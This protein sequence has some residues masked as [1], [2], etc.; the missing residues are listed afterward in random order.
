M[1][2]LF[3]T[4]IRHLACTIIAI[5]LLIANAD[6]SAAIF[7]VTQNGDAGVGSL[8]W[9]IDQAN[10][11]PTGET[12]E[13]RFNLTP[14]FSQITLTS[15]ITISRPDLL[16]TGIQTPEFDAP[17]RIKVSSPS[18]SVQS[19]VFVLAA[20]VTSFTL[21]DVNLGPSGRRSPRGGCIDAS[22]VNPLFTQ[23]TIER[24]QFDGCS[25]ET[26]LDTAGGA[27]FVNGSVLLRGSRFVNNR[28]RT[29]GGVGN[30]AARAS[31]GAVAMEQ[32]FLIVQDSTFSANVAESR[33]P[34]R[35]SDYG[36]GGAIAYVGFNN[37]GVTIID[38]DFFNNRAGRYECSG[39]SAELCRV[40]GFGGAISSFA[41]STTLQR[42]ALVA[43]E[44]IEGAAIYALGGSSDPTR[45]LDLQ[46]VALLGGVAYRGLVLVEL[47]VNLRQRNVSYDRVRVTDAE[48][49]SPK[50]AFL[51]FRN[52]FN[53]PGGAS[54]VGASHSVLFGRVNPDFSSSG[55]AKLCD[56]TAL[57]VLIQGNS[58][59]AD[60]DDPKILPGSCA[61]LGATSTSLGQMG[62]PADFNVAW[63]LQPR[64]AAV[65]N[66][67]AGAPSQS[68]WTRCSTIDLNGT[69]RPVDASGNGSAECDIGAVEALPP[70]DRIFANGFDQ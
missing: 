69:P 50:A 16:V 49:L 23:M 51:V 33:E 29:Q 17:E 42:S 54:Q 26:G 10:A 22:L 35:F 53:N 63:D 40:R 47:N 30:T 61:F 21:R 4:S 65:D 11:S 38:S 2:V 12:Q 20:N 14:A 27:V 18:V 55:Q 48:I 6:S 56:S 13:V 34:D 19:G 3:R 44:A 31:G 8:R 62:I 32:G 66:G 25:V 39:T 58:L 41:L 57:N 60:I 15:A 64:A 45:A 28:V 59:I 67:A 36:R 46:N 52:I 5:G 70:A 1:R 9:A 43:N 24:V 7:T 37:G 68:D